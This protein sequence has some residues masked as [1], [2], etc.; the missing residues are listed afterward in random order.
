MIGMLTISKFARV[1]VTVA[2]VFGLSVFALGQATPAATAPD[3]PSAAAV[4]ASKFTGTKVGTLAVEQ[5][6]GACN[7]GQRDLEALSK[8]FEPKQNELKS[9][10]DEIE[11][12]KKQLNAQQDKLTEDAHAKL[13]KQIETKQKNLDRAGED[14][15]EDF[16]N[17]AGEIENKILVKMVPVIQKYVADN[18]YGLLIDTSQTWPRG[19]V[20]MSG[21][22]I[23]ITQQIVD[24]YNV[25]SGVPAPVVAPKP[26]AKPAVAKPAPPANTTPK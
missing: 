19:P 21:P 12:L 5:A 23:D 4:A 24:A 3:A 10:N 14:A 6:I 15:K 2:V 26:A 22:A 9:L 25:Q 13:V 18:G 8:K 16:Q 17:Q 11:S 7:E 1:T 20:I